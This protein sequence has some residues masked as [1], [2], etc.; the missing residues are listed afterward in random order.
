MT[1]MLRVSGVDLIIRQHVKL[2]INNFGLIHYI[3]FESISLKMFLDVLYTV[4]FPQFSKKYH[5]FI[6]RFVQYTVHS[7]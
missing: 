6:L 3:N 4:R 1:E 5:L 7:D 2:R